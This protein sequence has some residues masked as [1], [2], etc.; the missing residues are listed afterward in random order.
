MPKKRK[1]DVVFFDRKKKHKPSSDHKTGGGSFKS[2]H[3]KFNQDRKVGGAYQGQSKKKKFKDRDLAPKDREYPCKY[4][5]RGTCRNG[6]ACPF[7]HEVTAEGTAYWESVRLNNLIIRTEQISSLLKLIDEHIKSFDFVNCATITHRL[8]K[9]ASENNY[10]SRVLS[11]SSFQVLKQTTL[12]ILQDDR[13][14]CKAR[15]LSNLVWS[16]AKLDCTSIITNKSSNF[17][18]LGS[19]KQY[20]HTYIH[21]IPAKLY[22]K[23]NFL[24][25][26]FMFCF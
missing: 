12:T 17:L 14:R 25:T 5:A 1:Q 6:S 8:A 18:K 10:T 9:I 15:E 3:Q 11:S 22:Y 7:R 13:T 16:Y 24:L 20:I 19:Y 26:N 4:F 2:K 21:Y 23:N